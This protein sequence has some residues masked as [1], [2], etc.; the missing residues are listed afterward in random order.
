[1]ECARAYG[2]LPEEYQQRISA[3][4]A[5]DWLQTEYPT[6]HDL[7][8]L[9]AEADR[10]SAVRQRLQNAENVFKQWNKLKT[11]EGE[12]LATQKRL[13]GEVP[14]DRES[15]RRTYT[16]LSLR[17][18]SLDKELKA[19]RGQLKDTDADID[20]LTRERDQGQ[21]HVNRIDLQLKDKEL[22]RQHARQ[23]IA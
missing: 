5:T 13:Q 4:P 22:E 3:A 11:Q 15:V 10:Y 14:D 18:D 9:R 12:K 8:S 2:E 7:G 1:G 21:A 16:D 6:S 17:L 23:T 19:K 20:R